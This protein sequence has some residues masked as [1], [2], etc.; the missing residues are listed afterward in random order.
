MA[1][2][3][4]TGGNDS[5]RIDAVRHKDKRKN[6]PAARLPGHGA[7]VPAKRIERSILLIRG[8]KVMLSPDLAA[9]YA[10]E[11]RALIQAVKR[12]IERFPRDFMFQLTRVELANL[13][14]QNVISSRRIRLRSVGT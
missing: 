13:K 2:K 8:H 14:S 4:A 9:L 1:R 6:I 5:K 12:N 11:P 3:K 7:V 10:V